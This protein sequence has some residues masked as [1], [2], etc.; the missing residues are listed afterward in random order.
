MALWLGSDRDR[1]EALES[2]GGA[3]SAAPV[4][5]EAL[6][7]LPKPELTPEALGARSSATVPTAAVES[8]LPPEPAP[9]REVEKGPATI[10]VRV[11]DHLGSPLAGV[12]VT[13]AQPG[14]WGTSKNA[15]QATTG[16]HGEARF[17]E[18]PLGFFFA[19]V[20][21]S[22]VPATYLTAPRGKGRADRPGESSVTLVCAPGATIEGQVQRPDGRPVSGLMV[23]LQCKEPGVGSVRRK[24]DADG[25]FRLEGAFPGRWVISLQVRDRRAQA[26]S[27]L[28]PTVEVLARTG[29]TA[30]AEL[31]CKTKGK[32]IMGR[33]VDQL[34]QPVMGLLVRAGP[35][36]P[37]K[38]IE[39][40]QL[41]GDG[42][43]FTITDADG[44]YKLGPLPPHPHAVVV[45]DRHGTG[46]VTS[47]ATLLA[48]WPEGHLAVPGDGTLH[49]TT[50][51]RARDVVHWRFRPRIS[52]LLR[53]NAGAR[54][55]N[56][57]AKIG[58]CRLFLDDDGFWTFV[59][60]RSRGDVTLTLSDGPFD[61]SG[62]KWS[63]A[64]DLPPG[65]RVETE[66]SIPPR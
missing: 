55:E 30:F 24:P 51:E 29:E 19:D 36:Y 28:P 12:G 8:V 50:V 7:K 22:T 40:V 13:L 15:R 66:L 44:R 35:R 26:G 62:Q 6:V 37:G 16:E 17:S 21:A 39:A 1:S 60:A 52:N 53:E 10:V 56:L 2:A 18:F 5:S 11:E 20:V 58:Y 32:W 59:T 25:R 57:H 9:E 49:V 54:V 41:Q 4:E 64:R 38:G 42:H 61:G 23:R 65:D 27:S 45:G 46:G 33:V 34:E 14:S 43:A 48:H 63:I 47:D 3:Q 31:L